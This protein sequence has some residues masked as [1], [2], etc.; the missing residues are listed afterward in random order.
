[1][2]TEF[3]RELY[4][5]IQRLAPPSSSTPIA[6]PSSTPLPARLHPKRLRS[7]PLTALSHP[8]C[9]KLSQRWG[10]LRLAALTSLR[11]GLQA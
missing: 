11:W 6:M 5:R 8:S 4:P 3:N 7:Y 2:V 10:S 1:M 9:A